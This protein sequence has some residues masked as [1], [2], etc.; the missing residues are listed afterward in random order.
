MKRILILLA[1]IGTV[2]SSVTAQD[3]VRERD[4]I[5]TSWEMVFD[6]EEEGGNLFERMALSAVSG[7]LD[8]VHVHF[9][10]EDDGELYVWADAFDIE[11]DE[12]DETRWNINKHGQLILGETEHFE[13]DDTLFMMEDGLLVPHKMERGK[14]VREDSIY[15]KEVRR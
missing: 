1:L 12:E 4:L 10:F 11:V 8:E 13:A 7:I 3:R 15:L 14:W 2:A 6:L 9:D 5:G